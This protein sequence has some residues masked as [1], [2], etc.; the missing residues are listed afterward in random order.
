MMIRIEVWKKVNG[1]DEQ[2]AVAFNDVDLG[3]IILI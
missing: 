1:L 3:M 2:F